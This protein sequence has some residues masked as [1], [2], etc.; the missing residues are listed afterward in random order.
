METLRMPN[1]RSARPRHRGWFAFMMTAVAVTAA[2]C[3]GAASSL[4]SPPTTSAPSGSRPASTAFVW[5]RDKAEPWN[6]ALN[7]DQRAVLVAGATVNASSSATYFSR[8]TSACQAM[9][10]DAQKGRGI[11]HAPSAALDG[12][13]ESMLTE[14]ETYASDC[15]TLVRTRSE[16]DLNT[17]NDSLTVMNQ[18]SGAWNTVVAAVRSGGSGSSG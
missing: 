8:L 16:R 18:A 1:P 11:A 4:P 6:H 3:G 13:W 2:G 17:W 15:L 14:T 12:A 10:H 7:T 9:L 5:L